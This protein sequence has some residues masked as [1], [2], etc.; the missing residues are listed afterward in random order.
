SVVDADLNF[1]GIKSLKLV[2][3][4][5]IPRNIGTNTATTADE[6]NEKAATIS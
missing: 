3:L 6:I 5:I 4:G 1:H 2:D